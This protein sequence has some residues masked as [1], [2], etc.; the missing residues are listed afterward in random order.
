MNLSGAWTSCSCGAGAPL[1]SDAAA[2]FSIAGDDSGPRGSGHPRVVNIAHIICAWL[3]ND[4]LDV[5]IFII[6]LISLNL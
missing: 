5:Y 2:C 6:L 3:L 1:L 4:V